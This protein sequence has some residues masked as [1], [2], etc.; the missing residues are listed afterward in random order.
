MIGVSATLKIQEGKGPEFEKIAEQA[1]QAVL[2][3]EPGCKLY[4]LFKVKDDE[5][6]FIETYVDQAAL[7]SH[8]KTD[9]FKEMGK[10]LATVVAGPPEIKFGS[11]VA[12]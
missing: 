7:E 6:V 3:N 11:V 2:D 1:I 9:H 5:Y 12:G 4:R 10:K 8:S